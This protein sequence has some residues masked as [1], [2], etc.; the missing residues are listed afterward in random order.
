M[1]SFEFEPKTN[2]RDIKSTKSDVDDEESI[3]DKVKQIVNS[4]WYECN[5]QCKPMKTYCWKFMLPRKKR[6]SW[7][8]L[9]R[10]VFLD[11]ESSSAFQTFL[12]VPQRL[13]KRLRHGC[14]LWTIWKIS[15]CFFLQ[16]TSGRL[17]LSFWNN[18]EK[19]WLGLAIS[20][21]GHN[22]IC[23]C[24]FNWFDL[25]WWNVLRKTSGGCY[26]NKLCSYCLFQKAFRNILSF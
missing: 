16:N 6:Y 17:F 24:F 15:E 12:T 8:V 18:L 3:E 22:L 9:L 4:E 11:K 25:G 21:N 23:K 1:K 2:I 7:M 13:L 10:L 20:L 14:F 5:K 26:C 19:W